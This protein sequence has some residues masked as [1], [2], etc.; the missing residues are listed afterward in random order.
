MQCTTACTVHAVHAMRMASDQAPC[1]SNGMRAGDDDQNRGTQAPKL[2]CNAQRK[3]TS[4]GHLLQGPLANKSTMKTH[5]HTWCMAAHACSHR[6]SIAAHTILV[7][8]GL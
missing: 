7:W 4:F 6:T 8:E 2:R 3:A 5:K 1:R